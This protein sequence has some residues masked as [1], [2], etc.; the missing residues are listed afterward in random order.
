MG[1]QRTTN[2]HRAASGPDS[3]AQSMLGPSYMLTSGG[4]RGAANSSSSPTV[5]SG[6]KSGGMHG[7]WRGFDQKFL[8][9]IFGGADPELHR[10]RN[11]TKFASNDVHIGS[12]GDYDSGFHG[13]D[14]DGLAGSDSLGANGG[15]VE[16]GEE[17][18]GLVAGNKAGDEGP[19]SARE[20]SVES[21]IF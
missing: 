13:A 2:R 15:G 16:L 9:P 10:Q 19:L 3:L 14:K 8:K 4:A 11:H 12:T 17:N 20:D 21:D 6:K 5:R 1:M 7:W 18:H